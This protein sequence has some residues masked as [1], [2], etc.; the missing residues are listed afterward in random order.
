MIK[1]RYLREIVNRDERT[2]ITTSM[3][4]EAERA[5]EKD[6]I[7]IMAK[8][9]ELE[10]PASKAA[11]RQQYALDSY[12]N[13]QQQQSAYGTLGGLFGGVFSGVFR[14]SNYCPNCGYKLH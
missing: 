2:E 13:Q 3:I 1:N 4:T 6:Y 12:Y 5:E 11:L 10:I 8:Y 14:S 7:D 9:A